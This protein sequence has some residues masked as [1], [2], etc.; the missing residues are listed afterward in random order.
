MEEVIE[1]VGLPVK[2]YVCKVAGRILPRTDYGGWTKWQPLQ[3]SRRWYC[4][5]HAI[6]A[7]KSAN[8]PLGSF[9]KDKDQEL[10]ELMN[11]I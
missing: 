7:E 2:C 10:D 11:L 1:R 5:E 6:G 4:P 8:P 3:G 9:A